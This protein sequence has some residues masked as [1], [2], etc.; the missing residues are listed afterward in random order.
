MHKLM[1]LRRVE[2]LIGY[3]PHDYKFLRSL[4]FTHKCRKRDAPQIIAHLLPIYTALA[5]KER[6]IA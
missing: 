1:F 4:A 2:Q 3:T 6:L 5:V